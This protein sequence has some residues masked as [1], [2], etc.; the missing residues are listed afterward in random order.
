MRFLEFFF[1][2]SVLDT[3]C[4]YPPWTMLL[5]GFVGGWLGVGVGRGGA[6][7]GV[8]LMW[9]G[10]GGWDGVCGTCGDVFVLYTLL[11]L[12]FCTFIVYVVVCEEGG[13]NRDVCIQMCC[14]CRVGLSRA[15]TM[16]A[17]CGGSF[18][19]YT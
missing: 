14:I 13:A 19:L 3:R 7:R 8:V 18:I 15:R 17:E 16:C 1:L 11:F 5:E 4:V 12:N 10:S 9:V 6:G 2:A